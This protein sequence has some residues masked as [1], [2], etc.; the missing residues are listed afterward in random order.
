MRVVLKYGTQEHLKMCV[1]S[2]DQIN[3]NNPLRDVKV[4]VLVE[5]N[6]IKQLI[7]HQLINQAFELQLGGWPER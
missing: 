5:I 4:A 6:R 7:P 3:Y 1:T 2:H